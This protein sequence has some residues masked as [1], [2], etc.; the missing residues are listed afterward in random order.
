MDSYFLFSIGQNQLTMAEW[1]FQL[2]CTL[3][4]NVFLAH[5]CL[6]TVGSYASLSICLSLDQKSLDNHSYLDKSKKQINPCIIHH[7]HKL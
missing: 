4:V 2:F 6:C 5:L 1:G 7:I 3:A